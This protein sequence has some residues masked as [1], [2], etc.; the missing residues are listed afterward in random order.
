MRNS[1]HLT[2]PPVPEH[3]VHMSEFHNFLLKKDITFNR[4]TEFDDNLTNYSVWKASFKNIVGCLS[5]TPQE[6]TDLLVKWLGVDSSRQALS[7]R[8]ANIHNPVVGL[9]SA[10]GLRFDERFGAPELVEDSLRKKLAAFQRI[11]LPRDARRMYD[12]VDILSEIKCLKEDLNYAA[13]LSLYDTSSG[14][15]PIVAKL[16]QFFRTNG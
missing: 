2:A 5:V 8:A 12:L 10:F 6:E 16:P 3:S 11:Q 4:F 13:L 15:N 1:V 14:V 9:R 7:L